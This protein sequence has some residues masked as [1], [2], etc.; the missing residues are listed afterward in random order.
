MPFILQLKLKLRKN[1]SHKSGFM[2]EPDFFMSDAFKVF[3]LIYSTYYERLFSEKFLLFFLD[4]FSQK[5]YRL[6]CECVPYLES[7]YS[8]ESLLRLRQNIADLCRLNQT[9][10][11]SLLI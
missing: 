6:V 1:L 2:K 10:S 8:D 4:A 11:D 7:L 9:I 5:P 3:F